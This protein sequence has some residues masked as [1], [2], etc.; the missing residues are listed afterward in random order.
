MLPNGAIGWTTPQT[1]DFFEKIGCLTPAVDLKFGLKF[2]PR[3]W[4]EI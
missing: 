1:S 3:I 2:S 4:P